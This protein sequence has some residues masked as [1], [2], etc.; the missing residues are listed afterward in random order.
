MSKSICESSVAAAGD[1]RPWHSVYY[2]FDKD[3]FK[4]QYVIITFYLFLL[5]LLCTYCTII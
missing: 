4:I 1:R 2:D 3:V 5:I